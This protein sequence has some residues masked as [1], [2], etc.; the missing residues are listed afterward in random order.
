MTSKRGCDSRSH[1]EVPV[2]SF[3]RQRGLWVRYACGLQSVI[4]ALICV[5]QNVRNEIRK[6][7]LSLMVLIC[8]HSRS[9]GGEKRESRELFRFL[10]MPNPVPASLAAEKIDQGYIGKMR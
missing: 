3:R 9:N 4:R 5:V 7:A 6:M 1:E 2:V 8:R 10:G